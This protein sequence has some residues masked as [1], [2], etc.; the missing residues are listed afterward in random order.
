MKKTL[1]LEDGVKVVT[2]AP[3]PNF[4]PLTA[5]TAELVAN[6]F[7]AIP[8]DPRHRERFAQVWGRVKNKFH[9]IE[10]RFRIEP[11]KVHGP[12]K[13]APKKTTEATQTSGNWSGAVVYAPAGQSFQWLEGDWVIPAV[14]APQQN[15]SYICGIWIGI[16]GDG[17]GAGA[18][19]VFQSGIGAEV[20]ASGSSVT[21]TYYPWWEWFPASP[22]TITNFPV[23]PGD[24][25]TMLLCSPSG[26]GS[27]T[28]T[29]TWTNVTTGATTNVSL[30]APAGIELVG[31]CAEWIVEAPGGI[32]ALP[33]YGEVFFSVCQAYTN[34]GTFVGGRSQNNINLTVGGT[35]AG[36]VISGGNLIT[37]TVVQCLYDGPQP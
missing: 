21:T 36:Q 15:E 8:D 18:N 34:R 13:G 28:G 30:T 27:T 35:A 20:Y 29:V 2:H 4:N 32:A 11:Q 10:P 33:D 1:A 9:Y 31:S 24:M 19:E 3:S 16:D 6:G 12:R 5:S 23:N 14:S 22:V 37:S 25:I 26:A 17:S 7:P